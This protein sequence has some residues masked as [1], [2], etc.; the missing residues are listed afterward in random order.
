MSFHLKSKGFYYFNGVKTSMKKVKLR[1]TI[2]FEF[3]NGLHD[4]KNKNTL[5]TFN[6][7]WVD[8]FIR[9]SSVLVFKTHEEFQELHFGLVKASTSKGLVVQAEK[10]CRSQVSCLQ[11]LLHSSSHIDGRDGAKSHAQFHVS[12]TSVKRVPIEV[13]SVH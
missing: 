8:E 12:G 2:Q 9:R 13:D 11:V 6:S 10:K 5:P 4:P 7:F 3:H 1:P